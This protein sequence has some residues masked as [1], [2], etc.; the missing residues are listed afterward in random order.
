MSACCAGQ[1]WPAELSRSWTGQ[2]RPPGLSG[3]REG[4][5][6]E[7]RRRDGARSCAV[8]GASLPSVDAIDVEQG[9]G[10][11]DARDYLQACRRVLAADVLARD[12][13]EVLAIDARRW[14][15]GAM[16]LRERIAAPA[17]PGSPEAEL[18]MLELGQDLA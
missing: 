17:S 11:T 9:S 14:P 4:Q 6:R 15:A 13:A 5:D 3:R 18:A 8:E 2:V 1:S 7:R 16:G 12:R 10:A